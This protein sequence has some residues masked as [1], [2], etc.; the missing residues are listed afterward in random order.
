[1]NIHIHVVCYSICVRRLYNS[2]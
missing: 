1:M 2:V